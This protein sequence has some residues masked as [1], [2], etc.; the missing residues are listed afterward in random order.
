MSNLQNHKIIHFYW[1]MSLHL[2]EFGGA[3]SKLIQVIFGSKMEAMVVRM[4]IVGMVVFR[5]KRSMNPGLVAS[6]STKGG[7]FIN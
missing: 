5:Y 3:D 6:L 7:E 4:T 1:F 2:W